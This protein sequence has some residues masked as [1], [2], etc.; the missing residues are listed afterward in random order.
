[1]FS[2][3]L[4][5]EEIVGMFEKGDPERAGL[6]PFGEDW[7]KEMEMHPLFMDQVPQECIDGENCYYIMPSC[8]VG[9]PNTADLR[10]AAA[11]GNRRY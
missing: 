7:E 5:N 6:Q 1:M 9:P 2:D 3:A 10:T 4:S 11:F 8:T